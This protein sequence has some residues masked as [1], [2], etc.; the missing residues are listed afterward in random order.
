DSYRIL[1]GM[2][3]LVQT[4]GLQLPE[5]SRVGKYAAQ[6]ENVVTMPVEEPVARKEA[7]VIPI[8]QKPVVPQQVVAASKV[9]EPV[10]PIQTVVPVAVPVV[11]ESKPANVSSKPIE[12]KSINEDVQNRL[13]QWLD[14]WKSGDIKTYRGYYDEKSF[15]SKGMNLEDWIAYK[16]NVLKKSKNVNISMDDLRVSQDKNIATAV[17]TQEYSSSIFKDKGKKTLKLKKID[18]EWK[19]YEEI[20]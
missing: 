18:D 10:A 1:S 2:G 14:S 11:T 3:K 19:I 13:S 20:M 6:K 5:E 17:F 12:K 4:L 9:E 15:K 7:V 8:V 16:T